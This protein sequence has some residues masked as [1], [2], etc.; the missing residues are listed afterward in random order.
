MR[1]GKIMYCAIP[2]RL[3]HL[4]EQVRACAMEIGYAAVIPFDVGEY[5]Y[6]EGNPRI[7]REKTLRLMITLMKGCDTVG[8]FGISKGV[9]SELKCA[10]DCNMEIHVFPD[11]D[12]EWEQQ[13]DLLKAEH[14]DLLKRLRGPNH[15]FAFVGPNAIGKTFWINRLLGHYKGKLQ[16]VKNTTTRLPRD[17]QDHES[18]NFISE[19]E[20]KKRIGEYW[21]LEWDQYLG[22]YYGSS[23]DDILAVLN[24]SHG[25]FAVTPLGAKA[26]Y[27]YRF[28]INVDLIVLAPSSKDVL[29][30][31]YLRR[32]IKDTKDQEKFLLS[33][34]QFNLPSDIVFNTIIITGDTKRDWKELFEI[35]DNIINS[36]P[37]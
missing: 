25:I 6:F 32:G 20:F 33:A 27:N 8:V 24:Q 11:L 16:R 36:N 5:K 19:D 2:T 14:G 3:R 21:F 35:I 28:E 13:Y 37:Q 31:N 34:K 26:L 30:K 9:M 4:R 17:P 29:L 15:L 1:Q 12:H 23:I 10:L 7:G 18:Y 22:N